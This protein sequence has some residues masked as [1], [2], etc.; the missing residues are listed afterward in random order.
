MT[1]TSTVFLGFCCVF[2][3][4]YFAT[5]DRLKLNNLVLV[6]GGLIFY[7]WYSPYFVALMMV[8]AITDFALGLWIGRTQGPN[9]RRWLLV[10]SIAVNV[11][12]LGYFK[13]VNFFVDTLNTVVAPP[14]GRAFD[15]F[16]DVVL[17]AGISFYTFQS[18]SYTIDIYLRRLEPRRSFLDF[19][20]FLSFFPHLVA[21]PIMRATVLLPQVENQRRFD[22]AVAEDGMRQILW[23]FAKK[24]VVAD[25]LAR[26]VDVAFAQPGAHSG[27]S[28]ALATIFFAFQIYADF[29]AY[30]DIAVGVSKVLGFRLIQNFR[31]PYFST[32][33]VDFWRRWHISLTSWFRD[34]VYLPLGGSRVRTAL[35]IRNV[36]VIFLLSGLWH[37]AN[38]TFVAW[39]GVHAIL[40]C[41]VMLAR[42]RRAEEMPIKGLRALVPWA[43]TFAAVCLAWVFFR[44]QSIGEAVL[45]LSRIADPSEWYVQQ[46]FLVQTS[47]GRGV[48]AILAMTAIEWLARDQEHPLKVAAWR[49]AIRRTTYVVIVL[50]IAFFGA[51]DE[52]NFIYFQF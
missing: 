3:P 45:I 29:S 17:P 41:A 49:P 40:Y 50:V 44:S 28:L 32:S 16:I 9:A 7:G 33:I 25:N 34:Y 26:L 38:L 8:S 1:F 48:A 46:D 36:L 27:F 21:G 37:G 43:A 4:L 2:F 30:S 42:G 51:A 11:G 14:G 35:W 18:M 23:G 10:L 24:I 6:A 12:F 13:Y 15:L 19:L 39:G 47:A 5:L 31:Y 22:I 52:G 20:G